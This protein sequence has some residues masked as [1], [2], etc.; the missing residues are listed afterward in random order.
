MM[1]DDHTPPLTSLQAELQD[2]ADRYWGGEYWPPLANL[3]RFTE[4]A[5]EVARAINQ[6]YG[7]KRIK[8]D[9]AAAQIAGELGDALFVLLCLANS[10]GVDLQQAFEGTLAKY[11]VRDQGEEV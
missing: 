11:R 7:P 6:A 9:E 5:G 8:P 10:T 3:A 1:T 2:W 4:E